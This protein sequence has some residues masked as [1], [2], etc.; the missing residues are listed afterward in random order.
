MARTPTEIADKFEAWYAVSAADGFNL[1]VQLLP[2]DRLNKAGCTRAATPEA[3]AQRICKLHTS[4]PPR[5]AT[6]TEPLHG[7]RT[8][9]TERS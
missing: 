1:M 2:A 7:Q 5:F 6:T 8:G 3:G 9:A 4:R